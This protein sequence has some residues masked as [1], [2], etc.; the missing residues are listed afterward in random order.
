M[1]QRTVPVNEYKN[2]I[3]VVVKYIEAIRTGNVN[4]LADSFYKDSV[5]YGTVDGTLVGGS[6]NP[7]V[8][9]IKNYGGSPD[10][11]YHVDV[12]DITPTT[13]AVR[14]VTEKDASSADCS[15]FLLL[16]KIEERWTIIAKAFH[17]FDK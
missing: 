12:L 5:T 16:I 10:L 1:N 15:E 2:V 11:N 9:F 3:H 4:M 13:A 7:A 14:V 17:Q 8:D 6:S